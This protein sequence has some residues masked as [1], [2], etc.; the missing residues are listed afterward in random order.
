M[1]I[2][3]KQRIIRRL[4]NEIRQ[5]QYTIFAHTGKLAI[6]QK[7]LVKLKNL[8]KEVEQINNDTIN[9]TLLKT[10]NRLMI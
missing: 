7:R 3:N 1:K 2:H 5:Q 6:M 4:K 10:K 9:L 8:K